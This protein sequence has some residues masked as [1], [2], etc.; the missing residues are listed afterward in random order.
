MIVLDVV[1]LVLVDE[2]L[3]LLVSPLLS[4]WMLFA[5]FGC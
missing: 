2:F 5:V 1:V 3:I 4:L